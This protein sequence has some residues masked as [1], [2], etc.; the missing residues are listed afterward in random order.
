MRLSQWPDIPII[1]SRWDHITW[2]LHALFSPQIQKLNTIIDY[3][4][5]RSETKYSL[6]VCHLSLVWIWLVLTCTTNPILGR[7]FRYPGTPHTKYPCNSVLVYIVWLRAKS[8]PIWLNL[9]IDVGLQGLAS[10]WVKPSKGYSVLTR[11]NVRAQIGPGVWLFWLRPCSGTAG[12]GV[13]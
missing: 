5:N 6:M 13:F 4:L 2:I 3:K 12:C 9:D 7:V 1:C 8:I 11:T 10:Q